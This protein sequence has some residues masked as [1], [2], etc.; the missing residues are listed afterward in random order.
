V[1][2]S[3]ALTG[4]RAVVFGGGSGIGLAC[5]RWLVRDGA[6]VLIASRSEERLAAAVAALAPEA[7]DGAD[8]TS[9]RG[10]VTDE[11]AV[12]DVVARATGPDGRLDICVYSV[13]GSTIVPLLGCSAEVF[14]ADI[15]RNLVGAFLVIR[16][17]GAA[18]VRGGGG[19]IV[20]ISSDAS[21]LSFPFVGPYCAAKAGLDALVRVAADELGS[22]GVRVNSV[23]PGLTVTERTSHLVDDEE[24]QRIFVEQKP[25]HRLGAVDDVAAAVRYLVGPDASWVTGTSFAIDGGNELRRAPWMEEAARARMGDDAVDAAFRGEIDVAA[26]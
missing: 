17:A 21:R 7:H 26:R 9:M 18:M 13:G 6:S 11:A 24:G 3:A 16:H 8:V 4:K 23:R 12:R 25:L 14:R 2:A 10:D 5:A 19:A 15:E 20:A 1:Q 22:S